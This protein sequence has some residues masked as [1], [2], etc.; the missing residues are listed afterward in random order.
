MQQAITNQSTSEKL[1][2]KGCKLCE[3]IKD[4][5]IRCGQPALQGDIYC[6]FHVRVRST[7]SLADQMYELPILETEQSVQIALQHMMRDLL[8]GKLSEKKAQVMMTGINTAAKLLRQQNQSTPKEALLQEIATEI[9][10][11]VRS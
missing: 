2:S 7:V 1:E 8:S 9:R 6:R 11:R 10:G 3:H 5:G 4:D